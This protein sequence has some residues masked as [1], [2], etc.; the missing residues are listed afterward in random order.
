MIF[1]Q[2]GHLLQFNCQHCQQPVHFSVF[3]LENQEDRVC[4]QN[5]QKKYAFSDETLKRQLKKFAALC[6]QLV[7]SEEIL[8]NTAIGIDVGNHHVKVPYKLLLTRLNSSLD[9]IIGDQQTSISFRFE[10]VKDLPKNFF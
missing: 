6:S 10:P 5:C 8:S 2:K 1:M 9:L 7:E 3:E 4:C